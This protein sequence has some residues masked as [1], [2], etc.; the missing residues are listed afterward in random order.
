[1]RFLF[2]ELTTIKEAA[3]TELTV[4]LVAVFTRSKQ[5]PRE[6]LDHLQDYSSVKPKASCER[7]RYV[8]THGLT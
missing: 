6:S 7:N 3:S 5:S 2:K 1:M 8:G 4:W